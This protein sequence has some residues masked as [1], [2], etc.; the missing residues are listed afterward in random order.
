LKGK[1]KKEK[2]DLL[3]HVLA[4][5]LILLLHVLLIAGLGVLVLFFRGVVQYMIWIFMGGLAAILASAYLFYRRMKKEGKNLRE[6]INTPVF[7]GRPVEVSLL[8]GIASIKVGT[9][10]A[11]PAISDNREIPLQLEDM[12]SQQVK[13]LSELARLF[14][15]D[16]ITRDE[17][18]IAKNRLFK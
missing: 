10:G 2:D 9:Q 8:G 1:P 11:R 16:L 6:M 12:K 17:Y 3:K 15:N 5:Y 14:E 13:E 18:N 4:V 7:Q